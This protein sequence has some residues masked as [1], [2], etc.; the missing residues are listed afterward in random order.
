MQKQLTET[1]NQLQATRIESQVGKLE[2][3]ARNAG[4]TLPPAERQLLTEALT[5]TPVQLAE[6]T[7]QLFEKVLDAKLIKLG[8]TAGG[9]KPGNEG[10]KTATERWGDKIKS[11]RES[12]KDLSL[13]D[14]M[15]KAASEDPAL[16]AD[17]T[18]ENMITTQGVN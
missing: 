13:Y 16:Y 10:G 12:N 1:T 11:L 9:T 3:K 17:Y 2:T 14:A 18:Q 7:V 15:N 5:K 4:Y 8:E 6:T